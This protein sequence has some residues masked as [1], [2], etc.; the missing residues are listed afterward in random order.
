MYSH[1]PM[2]FP[3]FHFTT[4]THPSHPQHN[5]FSFA[6]L[7]CIFLW[8]PV[9]LHFALFITFLTLFLK[10]LSLQETVP[11]TSARSWFQSW[12]FEN[13]VLRRIFGAK[14]DDLTGGR[15]KLHNEELHSLY[16]SPSII[17]MI[18]SRRRRWAGHLARMGAK[19]N[20][21]RILV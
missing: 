17:R 20:A 10:L 11:K 9:H 7:H 16:S 14:R 8:F 19:R 18:K 13:R 12:M 5:L 4:F 21:C 15:R 6:T 3:S 1:F 2:T